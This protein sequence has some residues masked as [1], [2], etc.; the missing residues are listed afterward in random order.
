[1]TTDNSFT[2]AAVPVKRLHAGTDTF[3]NVNKI[4]YV[5]RHS[6]LLAVSGL[7]QG[8]KFDVH[9]S[10]LQNNAVATK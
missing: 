1:M 9:K 6:V 3:I 8:K 5:K 10:V 4:C 2:G 7:R